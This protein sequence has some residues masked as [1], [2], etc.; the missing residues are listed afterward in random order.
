MMTR[1]NCLLPLILIFGLLYIAGCDNSVNNSLEDSLAPYTELEAIS[2]ASNTTIAI[3]NGESAGLDSYFAFD[4]SKVHAGGQ[5]REGIVEG[6]CLEWDKPIASGGDIHNGIKAYSTYGSETWKP[7]NYLMSIKKQLKTEDPNLTYREIQVAIWSLID[8]PRFDLDQVLENG[9]MP[10]RMMSNGQ[11]NFS[12]TKVKSIVERVRSEFGEFTYSPS[13]PYMVFARTND[14]S[15]NGGFIPCEKPESGECDGFYTV[16]GTVYVDGNTNQQKEA[17]ESGIQNVTVHLLDESGSEIASKT[18]AS[19]E[20]SFNVFTGN[21]ESYYTLKLSEITD[22]A[23]DF[24]EQLFDSYS[25]TTNPPEQNLTL[26]SEDVSNIN[27]GFAPQI[28]EIIQKFEDQTIMVNTQNTHYWK[29]RLFVA[30]LAD[31]LLNRGG[32]GID[33]PPVNNSVN[34]LRDYL[35]EIENLLLD[36]PFQFGEN[37]FATAYH[38]LNRPDT[39]LEKFLAELLTAQL[40][41]VSGRGSGSLNFDLSLLAYGESVAAEE[42]FPDGSDLRVSG[43]VMQAGSSSQLSTTR[44][45]S[46]TNLFRTFNLSGGGGGGIG[47]Q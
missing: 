11:P 26:T 7:V 16:S 38:I 33:F 8:V 29:T 39:E 47:P 1:R 21:E 18:T 14:E 31:A 35:E 27:F 2:G 17:G 12:I 43:K 13:T 6:W 36:E 42:L 19:G 41:V 20:F 3:Q 45:S 10:S 46:A 9:R 40:N 24:N 25:P 30:K 28:E 15:Q 5:I 32:S 4:I 37:K 34:E 22:D 44:L 23:T